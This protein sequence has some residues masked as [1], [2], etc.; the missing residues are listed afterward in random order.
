VIKRKNKHK[1]KVGVK[2]KSWCV[3]SAATHTLG[4]ST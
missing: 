1:I 4:V 3:K 2:L